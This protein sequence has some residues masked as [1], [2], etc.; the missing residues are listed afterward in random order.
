[1]KKKKLP[2][3]DR[4]LIEAEKR[5]KEKMLNDKKTILK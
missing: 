3:I 4:K 1:M 2:Q 5:K